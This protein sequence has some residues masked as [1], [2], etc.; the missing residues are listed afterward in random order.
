MSR[1]TDACKRPTPAQAHCTV[2]HRTFGG[3]WGFDEH[4]KG[5]DGLCVDP[6]SKG[7]VEMEGIWRTPMDQDKV[8]MFKDRVRGTRGRKTGVE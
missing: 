5:G 6:V 4:R 3:A 7:M 1:C 8:T 2:C